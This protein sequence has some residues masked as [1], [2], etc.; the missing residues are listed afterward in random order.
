[1]R[2]ILS[3]Q[4]NCQDNTLYPLKSNGLFTSPPLLSTPLDSDFYL[5]G[6]TFFLKKPHVM[7][8]SRK[9]EITTPANENQADFPQKHTK[10]RTLS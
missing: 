9:L 7:R 4:K 1:M 8:I 5:T 6:T 2:S 3:L 10:I